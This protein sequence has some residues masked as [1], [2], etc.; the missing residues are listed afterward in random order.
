MAS[1]K[2]TNSNKF[3][4]LIIFGVFVFSSCKKSDD[5]VVAITTNATVKLDTLNVAYGTDALQNMDFYLPANR[6]D[7]GTKLV[8]L[9]HGGAWIAGDKSDYNTE[10]PKIQAG[11]PNY[12][13]VN[14]NYRLATTLGANLWP[15]QQTD[16][17][18][19][20]DFIVSKASYYHYNANKIVV[21]GASAGAHLAMLKAYHFNTDN[22]IKAVVDYYGP[23]DMA[24]LHD[25][26]TGTN[27]QLF[28]LF[29][30]GTPTANA[31]VY[32]NA[33]PITFVAA[34]VP[35]TIIFHGTADAVVPIAQSTSLRTALVNAGVVNQYVEYA[36][37]QHGFV[38]QANITDSYNKAIAFTIINV[39]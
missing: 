31:S 15:T 4:M 39:H 1:F 36:G 13:F 27:K 8:V 7:T 28:E 10:I 12:A 6:T 14:I 3:F 22:R 25:F 33:S 32:A 17:N 38:S 2:S 30:G 19:A 18:A 20:F 24:A 37:E 9:I 21:M 26:Q 11:L 16:V 35:A 5:T 23:T 34:S 29:M